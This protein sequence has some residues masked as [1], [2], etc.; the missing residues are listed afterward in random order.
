MTLLSVEA[1][2]GFHAAA[3]AD[4][5]EALLLPLLDQKTPSLVISDECNRRQGCSS[6][7][8]GGAKLYPRCELSGSA[9]L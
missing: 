5:E 9:T 6:S 1:V 2:L 7:S 3:I 8:R 4:R